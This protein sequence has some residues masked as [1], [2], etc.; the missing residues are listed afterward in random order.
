MKGY[1]LRGGVTANPF[2][3]KSAAPLG[4]GNL[5]V[6][7]TRGRRSFV[8]LTPG[9]S[10]WPL[11][12]LSARSHDRRGELRAAEAKPTLVTRNEDDFAGLPVDLE[13]PFA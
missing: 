2:P 13:N 7:Q 9:Y 8:A 12:G 10:L 4:L 6:S 11:R 5:S 3:A 1:L